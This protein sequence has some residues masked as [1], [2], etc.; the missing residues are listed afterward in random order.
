MITQSVPAAAPNVFREFK[1]VRQEPGGR[2]RW[3]EAAEMEFVI[4]LDAAGAWT[5]FQLIY[6]QGDGE[7]ALTWR[8]GVGFSHS[9]IDAGESEA[10]K[11]LSPIL[12]PDGV[13]PW[14]RIEELFRRHA[15]SLEDDVREFVLSRLTERR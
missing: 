6:Q 13:V 9:R 12:V 10:L 5:G 2:R 11:N 8:R 1:A 14:A 3:F 15:D 4:W 7:R